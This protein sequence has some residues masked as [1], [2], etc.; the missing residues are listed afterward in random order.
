M[1]AAANDDATPLIHLAS[2][3]LD[4][5][6]DLCEHPPQHLTPADTCDFIRANCADLSSSSIIDYLT[7]HYC[8]VPV[9]LWPLS[10]SALGVGMIVLFLFMGTTASEFFCPNLSTI[11]EALGMSESLAGVTLLAFGNGAPDIFSNFSSLSSNAGG[12]A[13]GEMIGAATFI[14]TLVLGGVA[15]FAPFRLDPM[16]LFRDATF[17]LGSLGAALYIMWAKQI[18]AWAAGVLLAY[19][20][21]YVVLVLWVQHVA[22]RQEQA[23]QSDNDDEEELIVGGGARHHDSTSSTA[24]GELQLMSAFPMIRIDRSAL[25]PPPPPPPALLPSPPSLLPPDG[26][27][28]DI[29]PVYDHLGGDDDDHASNC[30]IKSHASRVAVED[31]DGASVR[32]SNSLRHRRHPRHPVTHHNRLSIVDAIVIANM[33]EE[34]EAAAEWNDTAPHHHDEAVAAKRSEAGADDDNDEDHRRGSVD[35]HTPS[36]KLRLELPPIS[37]QSLPIAVAPFS[38][39]T[40]HRGRRLSFSDAGHSAHRKFDILD[41]IDPPASSR[42]QPPSPVISSGGLSAAPAA[43]GHGG[44]VLVEPRPVRATSPA[45]LTPD[46]SPSVMSRRSSTVSR[47]S[48][49]AVL[50]SLSDMSVFR[51]HSLRQGISGPPSPKPSDRVTSPAASLFALTV[52]DPHRTLLGL[53]FPVMLSP[54]HRRPLASPDTAHPPRTT[55]LPP[56]MW[57]KRVIR[58]FK[59]AALWVLTPLYL[60]LRLTVPVISADGPTAFGAEVRHPVLCA[61][62]GGL[63]IGFAVIE[64]ALLAG[65]NGPVWIY[66]VAIGAGAFLINLAINVRWPKSRTSKVYSGLG[67]LIGM[68]WMSM[69]ANEC[70]SILKAL[71]VILGISEAALGLTVFAA[72]NSLGDLIA[73]ITVARAGYPTMAISACFAAPMLNLL[74]GIGGSAAWLTASQGGTPVPL[75]GIELNIFIVCV[76]LMA[77]LGGCLVVIPLRKYTMSRPVGIALVV[78]YSVLVPA[79]LILSGVV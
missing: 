19:Y 41:G 57:A 49:A 39:S 14:N 29:A 6:I 53:L 64:L 44:R 78:A 75:N 51:R 17:L 22:S 47:H 38:S 46:F 13:M 26:D 69:A 71:G 55:R 3:D 67:F 7:W 8:S 58:G 76:G 43:I 37:E 27:L 42:S 9:S 66:A 25:T 54:A 24:E 5:D 72:G 56:R 45:L 63:G 59:I 73:N 18:S 4:A 1:N 16:I 20:F 65:Y 31:D 21:A 23:I 40:L 15:I 35:S 2:I 60:V 74:L 61:L 33:M 12:L 50:A 48:S 10:A 30:S 68:C 70:I 36:T 11:A 79:A 62:Q 77:I 28:A 52:T 32:T 34:A